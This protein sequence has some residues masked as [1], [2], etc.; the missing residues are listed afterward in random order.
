MEKNIIYQGDSLLHLRHLKSESVDMCVTS[1]PYYNIRDYGC[2]GQIGL[3]ETAQAYIERLVG[4]FSEVRRVLKKEGTLWVNIGDTYVGDLPKGRLPKGCKSKDLIG[5]PWMLAFALRDS[6]WYLRQDIIWSKGNPLPEAVTDRCT[7][8]HEYMFLFSKSPKYYFD[9]EAIQEEA[10][11]YDGRKETLYNGSVKYQNGIK[12]NGE[13]NKMAG[14]KHERWKFKTD[15]F[16]NKIPLRNKRDVWNVN[17]KPCKDCHFAVFPQ[18]LI[19]PC[20]KVGCAENGIVLDP[21]MGSGTT[22]LVARKLNRNYIGIE[23][24]PQYIA[25]AKKRLM[26]ELGMFL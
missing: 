4:V 17:V 14:G 26:E 18:K 10:I 22:A 25:I 21:F 8:S 15:S 16:G 12:P 19:E 11:G 24:N 6:G 5:I 23:L 1:P 3:E 2:D 9:S 13:A 20:I 7:K